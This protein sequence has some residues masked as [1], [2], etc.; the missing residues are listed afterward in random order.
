MRSQPHVTVK[1]LILL[2][3]AAALAACS[4]ATTGSAPPVP[5]PAGAAPT[6]PTAELF[7]TTNT[8]VISDPADPRLRD[9]LSGMTTDVDATVVRNT[10]LPLDSTLTNGVFWSDDRHETT[11]EPSRVFRVACTDDTELHD[12]A[13]Q[14][15]NEYH[16]ESVLTFTFLDP[17]QPGK[18]AVNVEAPRGDVT[19]LHDALVADPEMQS[20]LVGG[21]VT[22][23]HQLIVVADLADLDLVERL[24]K[25]T[26]ADWSAATVR[27][28][29]RE[30]V[31]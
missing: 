2:V 12:I 5:C 26:G 6:T 9:T 7:A 31:E 1:T 10:A 28:G 4:T 18:T 19:R 25:Q 3:A 11:Y 23:D 30:F 24:V 20:K 8:A 17:D 22:Q 13:D 15:R 21:S 29:K 27:Y 16:Q 14:V